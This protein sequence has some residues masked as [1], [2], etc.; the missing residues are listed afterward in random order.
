M[1]RYIIESLPKKA[2]RT[3]ID[4]MNALGRLRKVF[5][6]MRPD[7]LKPK[8]VYQY[9][10]RRP[11]VR[12]NREKAV[13]SA[14]MTECVRWGAIDRNLVKEVR[15]NPEKPR[16]RYVTDDELDAFLE[17]ATSMVRAY[18]TLKMLTG[19]RQ[20]QILGLE[21][22]QWDGERLTVPAA[23][24]GRTVV[25]EGP[26]LAEA[27]V[28]LSECGGKFRSMRWVLSTRNAS[29]Y[30]SDGFRSI[31]HRCMK[32]YVDTGGERFTEHD[33]RAKVASDSGNLSSASSRM[34]HQSEATTNR[35]YRRRPVV[36]TV[37]TDDEEGGD[38]R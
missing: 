10:D 37:L 29:R 38:G 8:H 3:R 18:V 2:E 21:R 27:I 35:V 19:L 17:H 33:L 16:D 13:L 30:T 34:G 25:Y 20:G 14:L 9:L 11:A 6:H 31:W 23:K 32:K 7:D 4:Y 24:N 5:G 22:A 26:G 12:G 28:A 1:D 36:A 15:R